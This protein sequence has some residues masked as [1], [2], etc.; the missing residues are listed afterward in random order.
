MK[1]RVESGTGFA[2]SIVC[3]SAFL[4]AATIN[5]VKGRTDFLFISSLLMW[6]SYLSAHYFAEGTPI[7][8]KTAGKED[9]ENM[10]PRNIVEYLG[11]IIGAA[12][13]IGGMGVG[14]S[15]ISSSN[16][17]AASAGAFLFITGYII[18]HFS[19]TGKLL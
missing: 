6:I 13:L 17:P 1:I 19:T 2:V 8:G 7:D 16:I 12:V 9:K 4:G 11:S 5:A 14:A 15:G 10:T 18:T 3:L